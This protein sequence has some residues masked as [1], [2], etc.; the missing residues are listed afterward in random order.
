[1]PKKDVQQARLDA[2]CVRRSELLVKL[3][4]ACLALSKIDLDILR[5]SGG[6][7]G[8]IGGT[9]GGTIAGTIGG[10]IGSVQQAP[11]KK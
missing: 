4:E 11:G 6:V 10:T 9:I 8:A 3:N 1:M 5:A 7:S 2:L